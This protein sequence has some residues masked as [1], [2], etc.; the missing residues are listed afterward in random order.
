MPGTL[1]QLLS[2]VYWLGGS[3]CAGK[4]SIADTLSQRYGMQLY[5]CD[6]AFYRHL[7]QITP[8][9]QPV[10]YQVMHLSSEDLWMRPVA[11]QVEE[12]IEIYREEFPLILADLLALPLD[13]PILAEGA[14]LMPD[15]V[16][17]LLADPRRGM[18]VVPSPE[19]QRHHYKQRDWWWDVV[20]ECSDPRQA[21]EHWR[22]RDS[23]FA[24]QVAEL[25]QVRGFGLLRVDG[26]TSLAENAALVEA[27]YG[28]LV[29]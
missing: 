13:R 25:A 22:Q 16:A 1:D 27:H 28:Y 23:Q 26:Q 11:Q 18:W 17:A 2:H 14:A 15:L 7:N 19:F 12:T 21:F 5:R 10:F 4:S 29:D 6:E 9:E 20:R 24:L 3:P 8:D